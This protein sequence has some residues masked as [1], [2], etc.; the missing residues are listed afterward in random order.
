MVRTLNA[1]ALLGAWETAAPAAGL[2]RVLALLHAVWPD[3]PVD[4]WAARPVGER[5]G[6]LLQ[7]REAWFG[8][9]IES[10]ARCPACG[11]TVDV[12]FECA[13]VRTEA[14]APGALEVLAG[15]RR[16]AFR[17]PTT[18]DLL[19]VEQRTPELAHERLLALCVADAGE[20]PPE[21]MAAVLAAMAAADPQA[22]VQVALSCPACSNTWS[23]PFDIVTHLWSEIDDWA[24]RM[25][26]DVHRL[27]CAYG[28]SEHE[29]L[30]LSALRR[31]RY[32]EL[33]EA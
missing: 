33:V 9:R 31:R 21:T 13:Q 4:A 3:V 6:A 2:R 18:A 17:L 14:P 27:A 11:E 32:L 16:A 5:D 26:G 15:A 1:E 19:E 7:L 8:T 30:A 23:L 29:I 25:L 22:D 20:L 12:S 28:W 24:H 10:T